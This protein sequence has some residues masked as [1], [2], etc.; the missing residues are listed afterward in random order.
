MS[1]EHWRGSRKFTTA[2]LLVPF[3]S[4]SGCSGVSDNAEGPVPPTLDSKPGDPTDARQGQSGREP[5]TWA[6][7]LVESVYFAGA[8]ETPL[9]SV[10]NPDPLR[11]AAVEEAQA[12]AIESCMEGR[13]FDGYVWEADE[14]FLNEIYGVIDPDV[15][16]VWGYRNPGIPESFDGSVATEPIQE[17]VPEPMGEELQALAGADGDLVAEVTNADGVVVYRYAPDAC[18]NIGILDVRPNYF[19]GVQLQQQLESMAIEA[20]SIAKSTDTFEQ[21]FSQ[22]SACVADKGGALSSEVT[23]LLERTNFPADGPPGADEINSAVI[24][25]ECKQETPILRTWSALRAQIE[26]EMLAASPGLL[27]R[28][29]EYM[30]P[31]IE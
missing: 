29:Q 18:M 20:N 15:A 6:D 16:A 9:D 23:D 1:S 12:R 3:L 30:I 21:A 24:D 19:E 31:E 8:Y 17:V 22:W 14:A 27:P 10:I 4:M 11:F 26:G 2:V 7:D 28:Y 5:E 25:A 13:G